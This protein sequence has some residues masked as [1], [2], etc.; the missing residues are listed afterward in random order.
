MNSGI[1]QIWIGD[2]YYFGS[3]NDFEVRGKRHLSN[4]KKGKHQN[5][6]MQNAYNKYQTF[7]FE[8]ILTCD[9]NALYA[10]EQAYI[11]TH[12]G[13]SKCININSIASGPPPKLGPIASGLSNS[14]P[15]MINETWYPSHKAAGL[16]LGVRQGQ[17]S[18]WAAGAKNRKGWEVRYAD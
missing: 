17:I 4:L 11:D 16:A 3:T 12:Y 18:K 8:I 15:I 7:D 14:K 5:P 13:L 6:R 1:Y 9:V 2:Y 10:N